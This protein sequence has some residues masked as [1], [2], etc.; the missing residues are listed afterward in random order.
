[1]RKTVEY[2][3]FRFDDNQT[4]GELMQVSG[5]CGT[6]L[7]DHITIQQAVAISK[8]LNTTLFIHYPG[9]VRENATIERY[10]Y[11]AWRPHGKK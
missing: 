3:L 1:M 8:I 5:P 11:Y 10:W 6:P 4:T 7:R 9:D 2:H